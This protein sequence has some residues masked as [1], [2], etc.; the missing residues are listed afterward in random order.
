MTSETPESIWHWI[1]SSM[2]KIICGAMALICLFLLLSYFAQGSKLADNALS[3]AQRLIIP[4]QE[5]GEWVGT[6]VKVDRGDKTPS[7]KGKAALTPTQSRTTTAAHVPQEH[8]PSEGHA[9]NLTGTVPESMPDTTEPRLTQDTEVIINT[10]IEPLTMPQTQTP[11]AIAGMAPE[12]E[13]A[14]NAPLTPLAKRPYDEAL[15]AAPTADLNE[16]IGEH[17]IPRIAEDGTKPW[18]HFGKPFADDKVKPIIAVIVRGLGLGRLTTENAL[19]LH[20]N[21]TLSFSPYAKNTNMWGSHA[22]NIGHEIMIDLPQ[23]SVSYPADDPGPYALLNTLDAESNKTRLHWVMSR[24]PGYVGFLQND[25]PAPQSADMISAFTE[26]AKR[27]VFLIESPIEKT[28]SLTRQQEQMGLL[29][30]PYTRNLD[31]I[32]SEE[33]I[34]RQLDLLV[35]DAKKHG[36]AIA[37]ARPYPLTLELLNKWTEELDALGVTL[38]P[39]SA[40]IEREL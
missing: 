26:L 35:K 28:T 33:E 11:T 7:R 32:L 25:N 5:D 31:E 37:V 8:L 29:T 39:V 13:P 1:S 22:R 17:L 9:A 23:E 34:Q 4:L 19:N 38:A 24:I 12:P 30:H 40:V 14:P 15:N 21:V 2:W 18:K 6:K 20:G 3:N 16:K 10:A 36:T 27:G